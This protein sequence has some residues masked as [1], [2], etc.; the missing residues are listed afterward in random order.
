MVRRQRLQRRLLTIII[1]MRRNPPLIKILSTS[2]SHSRLWPRVGSLGANNQ[3][4][5]PLSTISV[6]TI[7]WS[8]LA[9]LKPQ[10]LALS[11]L[12]LQSVE[13]RLVA[14]P[15]APIRWLIRLIWPIWLPLWALPI[16]NR[17]ASPRIPLVPQWLVIRAVARIMLARW[18]T[19][20]RLPRIVTIRITMQAKAKQQAPNAASVPSLKC[21]LWTSLKC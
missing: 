5:R 13:P 19:I 11:S 6:Q 3:W 14:R 9:R 4:Q 21:P 1:T 16:A 7:W 10:A 2:L 12:I 17:L 20:M 15:Q 18:A 8:R